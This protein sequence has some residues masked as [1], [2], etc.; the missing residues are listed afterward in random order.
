MGFKKPDGKKGN[1]CRCFDQAGV[2]VY[3]ISI[4]S[5]NRVARVLMSE[6]FHSQ[7]LK[8]YGSLIKHFMIPL[9]IHKP[10]YGTKKAYICLLQTSQM[11]TT[12]LILSAVMVLLIAC[13]KDKFQ[14]KPKIEIK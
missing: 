13:S 5:I 8:I 14:T 2:F 1:G 10:R 7:A 3:R 4:A 11:K 9:V 12:L 6:C